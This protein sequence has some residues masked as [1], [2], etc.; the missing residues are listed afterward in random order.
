MQKVC[1][2]EGWSC[3]YFVHTSVPEPHVCAPAWQL[4]SQ[5]TSDAQHCP[6]SSQLSSWAKPTKINPN[7]FVLFCERFPGISQSLYTHTLLFCGQKGENQKIIRLGCWKGSVLPAGSAGPKGLRVLGGQM[8]TEDKCC[9]LLL[10][11]LKYQDPMESCC[12]LW[13]EPAST[14]AEL[15]QGH[16][17]HCSCVHITC[18]MH[19]HQL[20]GKTLGGNGPSAFNQLHLK[21]YQCIGRS[22][23][24]VVSCRHWSPQGCNSVH[25][26]KVKK[27]NRL[28]GDWMCMLYG[29]T[30]WWQLVWLLWLMTFFTQSLTLGKQSTKRSSPDEKIPLFPST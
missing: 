19:I 6:G 25:L 11:L 12:W 5:T 4:S 2:P 24:T 26:N 10:T 3:S 21:N 16:L 28:R 29:S 13:K 22:A 8:Q 15:L 1:S 30:A 20:G 23:L 7:A 17:C 18:P 27:G 14:R 9:M